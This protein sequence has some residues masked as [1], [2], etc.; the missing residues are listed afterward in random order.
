M[1]N[2]LHVSHKDLGKS[3]IKRCHKYVVK[4]MDAIE[5]HEILFKHT[6]INF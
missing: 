4:S 5:S 3:W 6:K 1:S 2:D